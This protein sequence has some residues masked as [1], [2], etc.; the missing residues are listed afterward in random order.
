MMSSMSFSSLNIKRA[1]DAKY[2]EK[3]AEAAGVEE[4]TTAP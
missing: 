1:R 4:A 2:E 3:K